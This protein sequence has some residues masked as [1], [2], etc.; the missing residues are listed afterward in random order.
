MDRL[1]LLGLL[2][3][4]CAVGTYKPTRAYPEGPI[5]PRELKLEQRPLDPRHSIDMRLSIGADSQRVLVAS[6]HLART[7]QPACSGGATPEEIV[8]RPGRNEV[9][10]AFRHEELVSTHLVDA[11]SSL[12]VEVVEPGQTRGCVR[13][14]ILDDDRAWTRRRSARF[15]GVGLR[16][17]G[18]VRP[19]ADERLM[20]L[21]AQLWIAGWR[22]GRARAGFEV[23]T[24]GLIHGQADPMGGFRGGASFDTAWGAAPFVHVPVVQLGLI[25]VG[26][27]AAY[28]LAAGYWDRSLHALHGPRA[29]LRFNVVPPPLR[30]RHIE[31]PPEVISFA[32]SIDVGALAFDAWAPRAPTLSVSTIVESF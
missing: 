16:F 19:I 32:V 28:E 18:A 9:T 5:Q 7:D 4:G 24:S 1:A 2:A 27:E 22:L 30:R 17:L 25:A 15:A 12:D 23:L 11:P 26:P 10:L 20:R 14:P 8:A 3:S 31:G 29:G 6:A 13:V 21:D